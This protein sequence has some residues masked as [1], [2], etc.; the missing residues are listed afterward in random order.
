MSRMISETIK[1][2]FANDLEEFQPVRKHRWQK[3]NF[4]NLKR[5][6]G[7]V[8]SLL[9]VVM[10]LLGVY[11]HNKFIQLSRFTEME[12]HQ[13]EVQL[14]RRKDL[15][16]NLAKTIIVYAQHERMMYQY[17]ADKRAD[18]LQKTDRIL[19][20]IEKNGL[21]ELAKMKAGNIEDALSKFMAIAEA[22][23]DLKLSANFQKLMDALV[24]SENR[25]AASRMEYNKAASV[26]HA[27]VRQIPA[28]FFAFIF[29]Y[30]EEMFHYAELDQ[31]LKTPVRIQIDPNFKEPIPMQVDSAE[32]ST[33]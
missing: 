5:K 12:Q 9:A 3:I 8:A 13:I 14:Q 30:K 24:E 7:L 33:N 2:L 16:I 6:E 21:N 20:A 11:Y 4:S 27:C 26:F 29:G 19:N 1:R 22:Y 23:P 25:I 31:D 10:I 32:K 18:T 28:S 15:A 17:M